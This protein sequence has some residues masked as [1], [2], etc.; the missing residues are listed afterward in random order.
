MTKFSSHTKYVMNAIL[1]FWLTRFK[2]IFTD[3]HHATN[4]IPHIHWSLPLHRFWLFLLHYLTSC[5]P[6]PRPSIEQ[7]LL[8]SVTEEETYLDIGTDQP[9]TTQLVRDRTK[10]PIHTV[11]CKI[12]MLTGYSSLS[13]WMFVR[14]KP[15]EPG[16]SRRKMLALKKSVCSAPLLFASFGLPSQVVANLKGTVSYSYRLTFY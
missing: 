9:V 8:P 7:T 15:W 12:Y 13:K 14:K 5:Q 10:I 1:A 11:R 2:Y 3:R 6:P 4:F 16:A